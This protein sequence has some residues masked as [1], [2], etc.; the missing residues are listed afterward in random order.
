M[1]WT[2]TEAVAGAVLQNWPGLDLP[3][4]S[5]PRLRALVVATPGFEDRAEVPSDRVLKLIL[6]ALNRQAD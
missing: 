5:L 4:L 2:D 3:N 6:F 1:H